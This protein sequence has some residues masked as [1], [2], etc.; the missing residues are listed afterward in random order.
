MILVRIEFHLKSKFNSL[1]QKKSNKRK[2]YWK[3]LKISEKNIATHTETEC[4]QWKHDKHGK[5]LFHVKS[6]YTRFI[7]IL[8]QTYRL[9]DV[10]RKHFHVFPTN[11]DS[12]NKYFCSYL[13]IPASSFVSYLQTVRFLWRCRFL[14]LSGPIFTAIIN[15]Q[16]AKHQKERDT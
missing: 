1:E 7:S 6:N 15:L 12:L 2:E 14:R 13:S 11:L 10:L 4:I 8:Y 16:K 3:T 5:L 9:A